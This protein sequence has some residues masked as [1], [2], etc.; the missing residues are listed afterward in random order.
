MMRHFKLSPLAV[1]PLSF[2]VFAGSAQG[3]LVACAGAAHRLPARPLRALPRTVEV[4]AVALCADADLHPAALTVVE[5]V[6]RRLLEQPQAP[7][8]MA[9]DSTRA[10]RHK[11][12]AKAASKALSIEGPGFDAKS[13]VPGLRFSC[14]L[15]HKHSRSR[16]RRSRSRH[17]R[18]PHP[19]DFN[20]TG[21][22]SAR[23]V[24]RSDRAAA[25]RPRGQKDVGEEIES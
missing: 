17:R 23:P 7:S 10:A 5:P 15:H 18:V 19:I 12:P 22:P 8:P 3:S 21:G 4:P 6:G 24:G 20:L 11:R 16:S 13:N 14:Y 25:L 9:L 2:G 1:A